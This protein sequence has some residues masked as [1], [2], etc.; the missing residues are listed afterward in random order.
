MNII[1]NFLNI[2]KASI[3]PQICLSRVI[4]S[5]FPMYLG[6][7]LFSEPTYVL[8]KKKKLL[9]FLIFKKSVPQHLSSLSMSTCQ[10]ICCL[11]S[12][13]KL[14]PPF[15]LRNRWPALALTSGHSPS[16]R[17]KLNYGHVLGNF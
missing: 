3:T 12:P 11:L 1:I 16:K 2:N 7:S 15:Q 6:L 8:L 9:P 4:P 14:L 10:I 13:R 5:P 17:K